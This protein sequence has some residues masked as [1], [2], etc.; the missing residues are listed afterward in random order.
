MTPGP[1][2]A[3]VDLSEIHDV[4]VNP[5]PHVIGEVPAD[6]IRILINHDLV[7]TPEPVI[8]KAVV[9]WGNAKVEAAKPEALP[10]P[11]FKPKDMVGTEPA[12]EVSMLP[13]MIEMVVGIITAGV[14]PNPLIAPI[15]VR[16]V[17]VPGLVAII[18]VFHG[19]APCASNR[20]RPLR[21]NV[22]DTFTLGVSTALGLRE[23]RN[24]KD[25][26]RHKKSNTLFHAHLRE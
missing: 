14:M 17:R 7:R 8:A 10:V 2:T 23:S 6:V 16:G 20:S 25:Q 22:P 11:S 3:A 5:Q 26:Q 13:R 15:D 12:R 9:V 18:A 1:F 4:D 19:G 21:R 24:G